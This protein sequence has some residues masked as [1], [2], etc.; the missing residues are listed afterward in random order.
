M[1]EKKVYPKV[2]GNNL[3]KS[4]KKYTNNK[5]FTFNIT[6]IKYNIIILM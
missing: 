5:I 4:F 6:V 2:E 1:N 3:P